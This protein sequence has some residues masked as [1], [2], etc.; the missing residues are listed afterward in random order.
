[1]L[2]NFKSNSAVYLFAFI[3]KK[4]DVEKQKTRLMTT[5]ISPLYFENPHVDIK[6]PFNCPPKQILGLSFLF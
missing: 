3:L 4:K 6:G 1:M 5:P 2:L